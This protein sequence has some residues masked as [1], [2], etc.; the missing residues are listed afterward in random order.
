MLILR[1]LRGFRISWA[2]HRAKKPMVER[3]R[4]WLRFLERRPFSVTSAKVAKHPR[5]VG[6]SKIG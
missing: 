2:I 4:L 1:E 6:P 3:S 5:N